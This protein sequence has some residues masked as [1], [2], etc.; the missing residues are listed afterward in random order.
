MER[1]IKSTVYGSTTNT[2]SWLCPRLTISRTAVKSGQSLAKQRFE[3]G[4]CHR[5][6]VG[7][8]GETQV[9]LWVSRGGESQMLAVLLKDQESMNRLFWIGYCLKPEHSVKEH[10]VLLLL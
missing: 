1:W 10:G 5:V 3:L 7:D 8:A 9:F 4:H 2:D 6:R